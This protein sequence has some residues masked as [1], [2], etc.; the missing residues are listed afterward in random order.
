MNAS[1]HNGLSQENTVPPWLLYCTC[2]TQRC[3][4]NARLK[5]NRTCVIGHPYNNPP[6]EPPHWNSPH[7][8]KKYIYC[9]NKFVDKTF[10][11][12]T[13]KYQRLISNIITR[14]WKVT[15]LLVMAANTIATTHILLSLDATTRKKLKNSI[16]KNEKNTF[17][18]IILITT[19][20]VHSIVIQKRRPERQQYLVV[21]LRDP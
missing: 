7:N 21:D 1:T 8:S 5:P 14:G 19:Q 2:D 6:P 13:I 20:Y 3:H 18:Q 15:L 9:N 12:K 16:H 10:A 17:K 4:R 11:M